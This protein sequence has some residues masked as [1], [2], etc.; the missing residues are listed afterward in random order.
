M[1]QMQLWALTVQFKPGVTGA[2]LCRHAIQAPFSLNLADPCR[3]SALI[4]KLRHERGGFWA[5]LMFLH[6]GDIRTVCWSQACSIHP[7]RTYSK[8]YQVWAT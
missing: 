2:S 6:P 7:S 3:V 4:V 8:I 5:P 1:Q